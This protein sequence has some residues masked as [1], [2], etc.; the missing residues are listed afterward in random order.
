MADDTH[1]SVDVVL[2]AI[3]YMR[4]GIEPRRNWYS[5]RAEGMEK[6][7]IM[8]PLSEAV[9]RRVPASLTAMHE[10]GDRCASTTFI[11]S[12]LMVSNRRTSP[13]VG[14]TWV[15]PGGACAGGAK[16]DGAAFCGRG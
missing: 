14:A 15:V 10:R 5:L 3:L 2:K 1:K 6:I 16:D 13:L 9:A 8:V 4:E 11:A 7:R 12:S